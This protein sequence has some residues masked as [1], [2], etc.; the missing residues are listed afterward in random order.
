MGTDGQPLMEI[1][2]HHLWMHARKSRHLGDPD[3]PALLLTHLAILRRLAAADGVTVPP[4][5][6]ITEVESGEY[7]GQRPAFLGFL[8]AVER[9]PPQAGGVL[10]CMAFDRL[11]RGD[12]LERARVRV[13]LCR[14]GILIRTPGGWIDLA[15]PDQALLAG[16]RSELAEHELARF[17]RRVA[18]ARAE[19]LRRGEITNGAVPFGYRWD[20]NARRP[21]PHPEE[22]RVLVACCRAALTDSLAR[23][24]ARYQVPESVLA[25]ALHCPTICGWAARRYGLRRGAD[26][27]AAD[28]ILPRAEW[29]W[30]E[31]P[32][33]WEAACTREEW[34]AIQ[35]ALGERDRRP[36]WTGAPDG[37]CRDVVRFREAAPGSWVRLQNYGRLPCYAAV[38]PE[39]GRVSA[40]VR[41]AAVHAEVTPALLRVLAKPELLARV[42]AAQAARTAAETRGPAREALAAELEAKRAELDRATRAQLTL[43]PGEGAD[44]QARVLRA[45]EGEARALAARLHQSPAPRDTTWHAPLL[46]ELARAAPL[47]GSDW[48]AAPPAL[49]RAIVQVLLAAVPVEIDRKPGQRQPPRRVLPVIWQ[50]EI[51][52]LGV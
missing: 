38:G 9:L 6:V 46:A 28:F 30:A 3:D 51:A 1:N 48:E 35:R 26:G 2:P 41:R 5:C 17:K 19:K 33:R 4:E 43:P 42:L 13:A 50:P 11:S 21:V 45:L 29:L 20:R 40:F 12:A 27:R 10:Y 34:E 37:W 39:P 24:A 47:T 18:L 7:L 31:A 44:S 22:F 8:E 23:L 15:D 16:V 14:A 52:D 36:L 32:G 49:K 25:R